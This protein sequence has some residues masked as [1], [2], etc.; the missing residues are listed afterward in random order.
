[1]PQN[2]VHDLGQQAG[3]ASHEGAGS[4]LIASSY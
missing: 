3:P 1:M 4:L 2:E